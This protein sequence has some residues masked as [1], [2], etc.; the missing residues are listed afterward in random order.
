MNLLQTAR[1]ATA[2]HWGCPLLVVLACGLP[3]GAIAADWQQYRGPERNGVSP[4]KA[5]LDR[6]PVDA[7]PKIA[8]RQNVGKGHSA[9]S[10]LGD[11]AVTAGWDAERDWIYCF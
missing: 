9:L 10:V 6:W 7:A 11:S 2:R 5:W 3:P 8:W 4:E 1:R